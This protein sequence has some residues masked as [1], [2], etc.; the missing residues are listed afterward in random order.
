VALAVMA[1]AEWGQQPC[2]VAA[3]SNMMKFDISMITTDDA[4][5]KFRALAA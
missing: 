4:N 2:N 1:T 5:K 3:S